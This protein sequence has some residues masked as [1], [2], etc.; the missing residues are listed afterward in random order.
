MCV[1]FF[2]NV[3]L[4][5][6]PVLILSGGLSWNS[7]L[8]LEADL[9]VAGLGCVAAHELRDPGPGRGVFVDV[10]RLFSMRFSCL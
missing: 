4:S 1:L 2:A 8:L 3:L 5:L 9:L 7:G 6:F 10:A